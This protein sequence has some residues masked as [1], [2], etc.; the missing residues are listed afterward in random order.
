MTPTA[1]ASD[2]HDESSAVKPP[3]QMARRQ[4]LAIAAAGLAAAMPCAA[5]ANDEVCQRVVQDVAGLRQQRSGLRLLKSQVKSQHFTALLESCVAVSQ[6][7]IHDSA[8]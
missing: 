4:L 2:Q 1:V 6:W 8:A 3:Q 7:R 5:S